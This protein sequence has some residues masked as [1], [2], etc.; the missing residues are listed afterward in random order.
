MLYSMLGQAVNLAKGLQANTAVSAENRAAIET[1]LAEG[2]ALYSD[3]RTR[4]AGKSRIDSLGT[5]RQVLSRI[6]K[7]GLT[8]EQVTHL[9]Q[10]LAWASA[11][12]DSG[13]TDASRARLENRDRDSQSRDCPPSKETSPGASIIRSWAEAVFGN[14]IRSRMLSMPSNAIQSLSLGRLMN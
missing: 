14:A 8:R 10:G 5:Y 9:S 11:A 1:Q 3:P 12:G 13:L 6:G 4:D 2:L 7:M